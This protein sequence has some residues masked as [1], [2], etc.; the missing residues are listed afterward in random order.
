MAIPSEVLGLPAE[1]FGIAALILVGS[2][3]IARGIGMLLTRVARAVDRE[4]SLALRQTVRLFEVGIVLV[5]LLVAL[6]VLEVSWAIDI[7]DRMLSI[8]P[9]LVV[10][11]VVF[12]LAYV[13]VALVLDLLK[14]FVLSVGA[15]YLKE[16]DISRTA[17]STAFM[18]I[19]FFVILFFASVALDFAHVELPLF[20]TILRALVYASVFA[21]LGVTAYAFKDYVANMLLSTYLSRNVIRVGQ[22][23]RYEGQSGEVSAITSH[24]TIISLESGYNA[25]I[26]NSRIVRDPVVVKRVESDLSGL[27]NLARKYTVTLS[28]DSGIAVTQMVLGIFGV[29]AGRE[30]IRSRA[31]AKDASGDAEMGAM[32]RVAQDLSEG[33]VKGALIEYNH[34][35]HFRQ[36]IKSWLTEE[37]LVVVYYQGKEEKQGRYRLIVGIEGEEFITMDPQRSTQVINAQALEKSLIDRNDRKG[38]VVF[39]K[40]GSPA[41]WRITEKLLYGDVS[42]YQSIS[43][44]L[45]RYLKKVLRKSRTV[46]TFLSPHVE[47]KIKEK[48]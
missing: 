36:E 25:I 2:I 14:A 41:F 46:N 30:D 31:K 15:S 20:D 16:F 34:A 29:Q 9:E 21:L 39:A 10:F 44:S 28:A 40:K 11:L 19:K 32:A 35:Y 47:H 45:E 43:K 42:A 18:I 17:V 5:G 4:G 12:Y 24:G 33:E 27:D 23:V 22:K 1:Q 37:A 6:S 3:I 38:Y 7:W 26:P 13:A 8:L 48:K